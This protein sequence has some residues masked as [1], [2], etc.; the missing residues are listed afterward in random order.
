MYHSICIVG[1]LLVLIVMLLH[2]HGTF[3]KQIYI[4]LHG[5]ANAVFLI[6]LILSIRNAVEN[7]DPDIKKLNTIENSDERNILIKRQSSAVSGCILQW[8][9][10]AVALIFI[11]FG[12]PMWMGFALMGL[13][14]LK[15][16]IEFVLS[17]YYQDK[18]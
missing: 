15:L 1:L 11:G 14:A 4:M 9:L 8:L 12:A 3:S 18:Y 10:L 6:G 5:F 13:V 16:F 7:H 2:S 17:I